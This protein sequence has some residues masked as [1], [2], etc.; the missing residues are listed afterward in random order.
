MNREVHKVEAELLIGHLRRRMR[1]LQ[2]LVNYLESREA[3]GSSDYSYS[4]EKLQELIAGLRE[5]EKFSSQRGAVHR[6]R[7]AWLNSHGGRMEAFDL[8]ARLKA[9]MGVLQ[10]LMSFLE[11]HGSL[12]VKEYFYCQARLQ[13]IMKE[14]KQLER[15]ASAGRQQG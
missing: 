8:P 3:V 11:D 6:M 9:Q 13:D 2:S 5:L 15:V 1:D 12:G 7:A 10:E 4:R 14:L